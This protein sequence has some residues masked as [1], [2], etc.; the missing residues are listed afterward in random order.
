MRAS[1]PNIVIIMSDDMGFSDLGCYGGEIRT[2]TLDRLA[3]GGLRF[4]QFYNMARCCPTRAALLTGLH[5]HQAGMGHMTGKHEKRSEPWQGDLSGRAVTIA[6]VLKEVGYATYMCGKWHVSNH[7]QAGD[8]PHNWPRQRGFDRFYGTITG[9]G[10]FYDPTTLTRDDTMIT[11]ENDPEYKPERFYY[12]DAISDNAARF[13]AD[14]AQAKGDQPFFLYVAYTAAH[15]PMHAPPE[16][17]AKYKGR[18]DQGYEPIRRARLERLRQ[19]GMID[20]AWELS[21]QA[22]RWDEVEHRAWEARCME[23]Y[24]AMI[25][26]M[27]EGIAKIVAELDKLG[28]RDN[29]LVLFLQDNGGCAEPMGR[30]DNPKWHLENLQPFGPDDL[31]PK[32]WPPMQ[33]RDG[34]AVLGG[35]DVMPG[36][37]DTYIGYGQAWANVSN[38]PFREY[39]HWVHEGGIATPLIAHWPKGIHRLGQ[40]EH[41]PGQ[42]VDLMATCV[43]VA[44]ATYPANYGGQP[45][46]PLEGKSLVN[47]FAGKPIERDALYW[48]HEGNRAVRV[49]QWKLVAKGPAGPWELY[50]VGR[51]RTEQHD[52]AQQHPK[53]AAAMRAKWEKWARRAEVLPWIWKPPY[54]KKNPK[55]ATRASD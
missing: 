14:H 47:A 16:C 6:E 17:I 45:I 44:G 10:S 32:I 13:I 23:V 21:E 4:S 28:Q 5:P 24:A 7:G 52:L 48:E 51:D 43:D 20:P 1:R 19:M 38:T 39:K 31:Q 50:D 37:P 12:T 3:E 25:E 8:T 15:W 54:S 55:P 11:P 34:R 29:T 53:R 36:G 22:G 18:Y 42:V 9:G 26:R 41:Q 33:T 46:R 27:D 30:E 35:P 2:P 49:G 40:I